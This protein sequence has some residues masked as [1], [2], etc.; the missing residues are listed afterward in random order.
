MRRLLVC[1]ATCSLL[2]GCGT[3]PG[4]VN[5][6]VG[7]GAQ[8]DLDRGASGLMSLEVTVGRDCRP[9]TLSVTWDDVAARLSAC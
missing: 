4:H 1:A 6:S 5:V 7:E 8:L 2:G 3:S 9:T